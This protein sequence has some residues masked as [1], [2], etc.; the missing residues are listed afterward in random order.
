M[1]DTQSGEKVVISI[2]GRISSH[3]IQVNFDPDTKT[4]SFLAPIHKTKQFRS[5]N[6]N[7]A[8]FDPPH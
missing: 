1:L 4:K 6:W 5:L 2:C 3:K 8:K 7:Q